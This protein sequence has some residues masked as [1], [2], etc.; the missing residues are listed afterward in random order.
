MTQVNLRQLIADLPFGGG[1]A[2]DAKQRNVSAMAQLLFQGTCHT[3]AAN[4]LHYYP[5]HVNDV[6]EATKR[7]SPELRQRTQ[8]ILAAMCLRRKGRQQEIYEAWQYRENVRQ[9]REAARAAC[10]EIALQASNG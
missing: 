1:L 4:V 9:C 10:A 2:L 3:S 6:L 7:L 5:E 8:A